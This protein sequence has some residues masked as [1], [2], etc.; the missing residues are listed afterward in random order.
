MLARTVWAAFDGWS[1]ANPAIRLNVS[2]RASRGH[3]VTAARLG[4]PD[5]TRLRRWC[6]ANGGVTLGIGLGMSSPADPK[7]DG[8]LRVAHMGHVNAH[9]TL[10]AIAV[11]QAGL[12]A[13]GIAHG[14]GLTAAAREVALG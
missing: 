14:D 4:S 1:A 6:E 12:Q 5:A 3:S 11:M 13:L 10:G 8:A 9:M 2:D 7:A